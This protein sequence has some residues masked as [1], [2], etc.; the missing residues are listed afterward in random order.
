MHATVQVVDSAMNVWQIDGL[1]SDWYSQFRET[2][3]LRLLPGDGQVG[4]KY[5]RGRREAHILH[6]G[7]S[8][9]WTHKSRGDLSEGSKTPWSRPKRKLGIGIRCGALLVHYRV[10]MRSRGANESSLNH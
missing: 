9:H 6:S 4:S 5:K 1:E 2:V 8:H 10:Q 7:L 3:H